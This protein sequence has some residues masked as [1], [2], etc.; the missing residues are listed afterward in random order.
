MSE[1]KNPALM[2]L[3][4]QQVRF[5]PPTRRLAQLT[6]AERLLAEVEEDVEAEPVGEYTL[7]GFSKPLPVFN[8]VGVHERAITEGEPT[9]QTR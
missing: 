9:A 6:R 3:T 8:I 2:Q 5:A 1:F 4:D 7:K